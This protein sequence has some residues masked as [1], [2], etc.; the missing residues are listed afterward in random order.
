MALNNGTWNN[1]SPHNTYSTV[2][3]TLGI[4]FI[5]CSLTA[6]VLVI[7]VIY[8]FRSMRTRPNLIILNLSVSDVLYTLAVTPVNAFYWSTN[9][10]TYAPAVCYIVGYLGYLFCLITIYTIVFAN[11]ERFIATNYPMK[12]RL[13]FTTKVVQIGVMVIWLWSAGLCALPFALYP[14]TS[15]LKYITT[16]WSTG[17]RI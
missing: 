9:K 3:L 8:R 10:E 14:D 5:I 13:M 7:Y 16:A 11:I 17:Q 12:H 15:M 2:R 6:N 4:I 1:T